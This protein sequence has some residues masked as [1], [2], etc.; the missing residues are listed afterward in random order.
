MSVL[1]FIF[2]GCFIGSFNGI[3]QYLAVGAIMFAIQYTI[4]GKP[5]HFYFACAIAFLCHT[6]AALFFVFYG[7]VRIKNRR[8]FLLILGI[9]SI[10][11]LFSYDRI[12]SL[13]DVVRGVSEG[14]TSEALFAQQRVNRLRVLV[15]WAPV[16]LFLLSDELRADANEYDNVIINMVFVEAALQT[17]AINSSYL[18]RFCFYTNCANILA[19]PA[20]LKHHSESNKKFLSVAVYVLYFIYWLAQARDAFNINYHWCF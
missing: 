12:F 4:E 3:R 15:A 2:L 13:I 17:V 6:S 11:L 9:A 8:L 19:I 18:A 5:K 16:L 20:L 7:L 1:L 14:T 10:I